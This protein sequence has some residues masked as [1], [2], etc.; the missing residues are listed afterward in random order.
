MPSLHVDGKIGKRREKLHIV[1]TYAVD[2]A[3]VILPRLVVV[4]CIGAER[5][6]EARQVMAVLAPDVF[7]DKRA[8]R[9][10]SLGFRFEHEASPSGDED[11]CGLSKAFMP[12]Q[13][14]SEVA[15]TFA[16]R[17]RRH[18]RFVA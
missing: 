1:R 5:R 7:F 15:A 14:P 13:A 2:A 8:L 4:V 17:L 6:H 12:S 18:G 3:A 11:A 10:E 16:A 9:R